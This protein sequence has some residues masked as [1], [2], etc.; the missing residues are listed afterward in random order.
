M[1]MTKS[2]FVIPDASGPTAVT[3][4]TPSLP[5]TAGSEECSKAVADGDPERTARSTGST[6]AASQETCTFDP[7]G[8]VEAFADVRDNM[9]CGSPVAA[10]VY[11]V[12]KDLKLRGELRRS[13]TPNIADRIMTKTCEQLANGMERA[14]GVSGETW[15]VFSFRKSP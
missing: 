10:Y 4:A 6:P 15:S 5:A 14:S 8:G 11:A 9:V 12:D 13:R 1:G 7:V 2:P 3:V